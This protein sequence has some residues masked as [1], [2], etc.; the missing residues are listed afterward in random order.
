[1]TDE[2]IPL[3]RGLALISRGSY[4]Q[5]GAGFLR[6]LYPNSDILVEGVPLDEL[7]RE[8]RCTWCDGAYAEDELGGSYDHAQDC[9]V[10]VFAYA[11]VAAAEAQDAERAQ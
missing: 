2:V 11:M 4:E 7:E 10:L 8:S 6:K 1:V 3:T 9:G 5:Y